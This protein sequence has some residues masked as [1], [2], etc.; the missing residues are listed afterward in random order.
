[1][2]KYICLA[3]C[4]FLLELYGMAGKQRKERLKPNR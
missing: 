2:A 3:S 4:L 1:M